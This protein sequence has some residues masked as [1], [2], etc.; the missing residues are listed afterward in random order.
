M[1]VAFFFRN[2]DD[3]LTIREVI[4][5][6]PEY[7]AIPNRD[8]AVRKFRRDRDDLATAHIAIEQRHETESEHEALGERYRYRM[9]PPFFDEAERRELIEAAAAVRIEGLEEDDPADLGGTASGVAAM[10]AVTIPAIVADLREPIAERCIVA[11]RY[12]DKERRIEP[13]RV[14]LWR[15]T[16]YLIARDLAD[17]K[18]KRWAIERIAGV[19]PHGPAISVVSPPK[20]FVPARLNWAEQFALDPNTWGGDPPLEAS[21]LIKRAH[22]DRFRD[23]FDG[24]SNQEWVGDDEVVVTFTVRHLESTITRLLGF[25][26]DALVVGP[27]ELRDAIRAWLSPQAEES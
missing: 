17:A 20:A 10:A 4:D 7:A 5:A 2:L 8:S 19:D 21:V 9:P 27:P 16:W 23:V 26:E 22:G 13:Y 3:D 25:G 15:N 14:G 11:F 1:L 24:V 6:I 18:V 12:K